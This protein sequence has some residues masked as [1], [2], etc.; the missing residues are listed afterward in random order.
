MSDDG[1]TYYTILYV[2]CVLCTHLK[3]CHVWI[4]MIVEYRKMQSAPPYSST[5]LVHYAGSAGAEQSGPA[6]KTLQPSAA[7]A[8]TSSGRPSSCIVVRHM[9]LRPAWLSGT[10]VAACTAT[11]CTSAQF[12]RSESATCACAYVGHPSLHLAMG[13]LQGH[14]M[15]LERWR[16][17]R[18]RII[19]NN[20]IVPL[21]AMSEAEGA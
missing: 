13:G 4:S 21:P 12:S 18:A 11:I 10:R 9:H 17:T 3:I 7:A 8:S 1:C 16:R 15:W 5:V 2:D 14:A 20:E 19:P 6:A